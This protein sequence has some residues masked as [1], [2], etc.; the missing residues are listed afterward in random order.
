MTASE[1]FKK[2]REEEAKYLS[3][4]GTRA[5]RTQKKKEEKKPEGEP[6]KEPK[7][8]NLVEADATKRD[9]YG[10]GRNMMLTGALMK[11]EKDMQESKLDYEQAFMLSESGRIIAQNTRGSGYEVDMSELSAA[12]AEDKIV[13]HIHPAEDRVGGKGIARD[14]GTTLSCTDLLWAA[15]NG[16]REMRAVATGYVYSMRPK[17]GHDWGKWGQGLKLKPN[18]TQQEAEKVYNNIKAYTREYNYY[19]NEYKRIF[20]NGKGGVFAKRFQ[21]TNFATTEARYN[22]ASQDYAMRKLA[23]KYGWRYQRYK[24]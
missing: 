23:E 6:K 14:I 4:A 15:Q 24:I 20:L 17:S 12:G 2:K 9:I 11:L 1:Y 21:S 22:I 10:D 5:S 7:Y 16:V 8:K 3:G 13:T 18:M 19:L